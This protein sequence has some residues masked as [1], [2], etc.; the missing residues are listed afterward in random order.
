MV[1][2]NSSPGFLKG[3]QSFSLDIGWF[4]TPLQFSPCAW[5]FSEER[6]FMVPKTELWI[7]Q[8]WSI[9]L[10]FADH[11]KCRNGGCQEVTYKERKQGEKAEVSQITQ[12]LHWKSVAT[13]GV[14][15]PNVK[16]V[17]CEICGTN[18]YEEKAKRYNCECL[19]PPVKHGGGSVIV[20]GCI[21]A[22][23]WWKNG[24]NY[25][26]RKVQSDFNPPYHLES[27][28]YI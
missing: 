26:H 9:D 21:S 23:C 17:K 7:I 16:F 5:L 8:A 13:G 3:F 20:W 25:E 24:W 1:L 6:F 14:I 15:N 2:R 4:V 27:S 10:L 18:M 28:V 22:S 11:Q 19:Q 12:E